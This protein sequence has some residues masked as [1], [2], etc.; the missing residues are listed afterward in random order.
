MWVYANVSPSANLVQPP[1][2]CMLVLL[3]LLEA[4]TPLQGL[5]LSNKFGKPAQVAKLP[6]T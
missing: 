6:L 2:T 3:Q 4:R 1:A 5:M